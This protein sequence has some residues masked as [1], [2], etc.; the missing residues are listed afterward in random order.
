MKRVGDLLVEVKEFPQSSDALPVLT[1]TEGRGFVR[2]DERFKKR[3]AVTDTRCYKVVRRGDVSFNPYL[4]WA[5]AVASNEI[6]EVGL[7]SPAYPTFRVRSGFDPRFVALLLGSPRM[8]A[9]YDAISFGSVPRRRRASVADFLGLPVEYV[10]TLDEQRRIADILDRANALFAFRGEQ[11]R[12]LQALPSS[13]FS[14]LFGVPKGCPVVSLSELASITS[15]V[16]KGRKAT[17][18]L[19]EV[20]Y[21]AVANVQAGHLRMDQVKTM[22]VTSTE[23]ERFSLRNGDLVMTEGGDPDKLGRGALWRGELPLCLHQN[24]VFRVRVAAEG[25]VLPEY[26]EGFLADP[27]ARVYFRRCAKQTTGIA[28]INMTQLKQ[29]PVPVPPLQ[30]Q[31]EYAEVTRSVRGHLRRLEDLLM[32]E[33]ELFASLQARAFR[34]EL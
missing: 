30:V 4:L 29:L 20:P 19:R 32:A 9:S 24:H 23:V 3:I 28:S 12:A 27:R 31:R 2:Q 22:A 33:E 14:N 7:T 13:V 5:G 11:R 15:G 1:L 25:R 8:I 18:V 26:L 17:G 16:T 6:A 10:P 34:G 21:L